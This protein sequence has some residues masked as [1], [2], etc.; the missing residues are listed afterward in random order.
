MFGWCPIEQSSGIQRKWQHVCSFRELR[1]GGG[2]LACLL[3]VSL[4]CMP[5]SH[6]SV[7]TQQ[8]GQAQEGQ[9]REQRVPA[10]A[11]L[12]GGIPGTIEQTGPSE[13]IPH[14]A[15]QNHESLS[16]LL[17][18]GKRIYVT[19]CTRCHGDQGDGTGELSSSLNPRPADFTAGIFKF[20]STPTGQLPTSDDLFRTISVGV[21][22]TS[23]SDYS[24]LTVSDRRAVVE[25]VMNF[26]PRFRE[27]SKGT[28]ILAPPIRPVTSEAVNRGQVLYTQM[29]CDACHGPYAR[30]DGALAQSLS[31]SNGRKIQPADLTRTRLKS[32]KGP[33]A[34]YRVLMTG[35]DGTPMPSYG[36]SLT[37]DEAWDLAL[38]VSSLSTSGEI[39]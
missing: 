24:E 2:V 39:P 21:A 36:D 28:T 20:R 32:G 37:Q 25:Y 6:P 17:A 1:Y 22:G 18:Q 38:Y 16:T 11:P 5:K 30:G 31:D 33:T 27:E 9:V 19:H 8:D 4:G 23:M 10:Q 12:L 29:F 34:I 15:Y 13:S 35:L 26:S 3:L 14:S 7:P